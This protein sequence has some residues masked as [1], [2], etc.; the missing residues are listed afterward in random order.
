[1]RHPHILRQLNQEQ[2][3]LRKSPPIEMD[4]GLYKAKSDW[5]IQKGSGA[6]KDGWMYGIAWNSSTWED[7]EGFFD[8][9]RKRR[10]TR[11]YT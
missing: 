3:A 7:R 4:D 11:I 10:W 9:T 6:D 5:S 1:Y 8:T 2:C